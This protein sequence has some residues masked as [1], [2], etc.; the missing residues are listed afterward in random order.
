MNDETPALIGLIILLLGSLYSIVSGLI[1]G[2]RKPAFILLGSFLLLLLAA[3]VVEAYFS[4]PTSSRGFHEREM[5]ND[6][7]L[8]VVFLIAPLI[9][10]AYGWAIY[11]EES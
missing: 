1:S 4:G 9:A 2:P 6:V 8:R 3:M 5:L 7:A 10:G 11:R